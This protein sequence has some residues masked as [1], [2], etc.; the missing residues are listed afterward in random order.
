MKDVKTPQTTGYDKLKYVN[1]GEMSNKGFEFRV[2]ADVYKDRMWNVRVSANVSRNLNK[3]EKLPENWTVENY[4][5]DN[6]N[7][8][9]CIVEGDPIGSFYGYK[10]K[11]VY[12]NTEDTYAYDANGNV[13]RD[14]QGEVVTMR[15]G[16]TPVYPGDAKYEDVMVVRRVLSVNSRLRRTAI[17]V[18]ARKL[19][20]R[21]VWIWRICM[22]RAIRV[23]PCFAV[24]ARRETIPTSHVPSLAWVT[25]T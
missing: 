14:F 19:S 17:S 10:Y 3:I 5:F 16:N 4:T 9:V 25:T 22:V 13:M 8:A 18:L 21:P 2:D 6:G 7:Y 23:L 12:K 1:S 24:G 20:T 15:N 11:G